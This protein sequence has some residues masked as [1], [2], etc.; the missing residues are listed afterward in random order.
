MKKFSKIIENTNLEKKYIIKVELEIIV[1]AES[2]GEAGYLADSIISGI[3][4]QYNYSII[5]I[6]EIDEDLQK[7]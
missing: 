2:E 4:E 1:N 6:E 3:E 7:N 5:N